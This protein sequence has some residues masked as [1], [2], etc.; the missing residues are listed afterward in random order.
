M[1]ECPVSILRRDPSSLLAQLT[2]DEPSIL[3]DPEGFFAFDRDWWLFRYIMAFLRDGT[4][5]EDRAL[6]AQLYREASFWQL[7]ELQRAIEEEKLHLRTN[8]SKH[9]DSS[10]ASAEEKNKEE[11]EKKRWW[12][13]MP[14]WQES[15]QKAEAETKEKSKKKTDWWTGTTY[16]N[17]D[18]LPLPAGVDGKSAGGKGGD[19]SSSKPSGGGES[20]KPAYTSATWFVPEDRGKARG[21]YGGSSGSGY[22]GGGGYTMEQVQKL[23]MPVTVDSQPGAGGGVLH[24]RMPYAV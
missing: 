12:R 14:S 11:E 22:R 20:S 9:G 15:V 24:P 23:T 4:L 2:E 10:S 8:K 18:F 16:N 5:P 17:Q 21:E 1:F 7:V 3:R 13:K 6:L 19:S